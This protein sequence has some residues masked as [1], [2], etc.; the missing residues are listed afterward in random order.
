MCAQHAFLGA[1]I[2]HC[3]LAPPQKSTF[4]GPSPAVPKTHFLGTGGARA[5]KST[6]LGAATSHM[7]HDSCGN[8]APEDTH[9]GFS[10]QCFGKYVMLGLPTNWHLASSRE[11][12]PQAE[13]CSPIL[14]YIKG[15]LSIII[16]PESAPDLRCP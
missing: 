9:P 12:V 6:S 14:G 8:T 7:P 1:R 15:L 10:L 4:C 16:F 5:Q 2:L 13:K 3:N 11:Q